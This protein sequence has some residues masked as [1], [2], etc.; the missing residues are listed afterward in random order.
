MIDHNAYQLFI[1]LVNQASNTPNMTVNAGP[2]TSKDGFMRFE[3]WRLRQS[4]HIAFLSGEVTEQVDI[5]AGY[6]LEALGNDCYAQFSE[7]ERWKSAIEV[8]K[9]KQTRHTNDRIW[10]R[11]CKVAEAYRRLKV[12]NYK[13]SLGSYGVEWSTTSS[14]DI[15]GKIDGLAALLGGEVILKQM[16]GYHKNAEKVFDDMWLFGE[17]SLGVHQDKQPSV[18]VGWMLALAAKHMHRGQKARKPEVIWQT[19]LT[20]MVDFCATFDCERYGQFEQID[21]EPAQIPEAIQ[22]TLTWNAFFRVNQTHSLAIPAIMECI[23][24]GADEHDQF[25]FVKKVK[26]LWNEYRHLMNHLN[27]NSPLSISDMY[28]RRDFPNLLKSSTGFAKKVN[29]SFRHPMDGN[30]CNDGRF[31]FI[32]APK[33]MLIVRPLSITNNAFLETV[34][35][36]FWAEIAKETASKIAGELF[37]KAILKAT[38]HHTGDVFHR[39]TYRSKKR[40]NEFDVALREEQNIQL[41]EVKGKNLTSAATAGNTIKF[42]EDIA[43][44]FMSLIEQLA[45]HEANIRNVDTPINKTSDSGTSLV[46]EKIAVSPLSFGPVSDKGFLSALVRALTSGQLA[47][48]NENSDEIET[49]DEFNS[50]TLKAIKSIQCAID[51]SDERS[52]FHTF[53]LFSQWLDLSQVLY[54]IDQAHRP[55]DAFRPLR[56]LTFQSRDFWTEIAFASKQG[57]TEKHWS[58]S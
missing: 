54:C 33:K 11:T 32:S 50:K 4:I 5:C 29:R 2:P 53:F 17:I 25:V 8:A 49:I 3:F 39:K 12:A 52:D 21:I 48:L 41:F 27:A 19:L 9:S 24:D 35:R 6:I 30:E 18:P 46:V 14:Q 42:I 1:D 37:E 15:V 57:L 16:C 55:I 36:C 56:H 34:F 7:K 26:K 13:P 23:I 31:V 38:S 58:K 45:R 20:N 28:A 47:S 51:A 10:K 43:G 40:E 44:S 22:K